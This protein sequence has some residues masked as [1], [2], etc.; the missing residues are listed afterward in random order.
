MAHAAVRWPVRRHRTALYM[1]PTSPDAALLRPDRTFTWHIYTIAVFGVEPVPRC[2]KKSITTLQP[3]L[4]I[5]MAWTR[6]AGGSKA[7]FPIMNGTQKIVQEAYVGHHSLRRLAR[8]S[9]A[10]SP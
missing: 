4:P 1:A 5:D 10:L 3:R 8:D 6:L 9:L 2:A 7:K